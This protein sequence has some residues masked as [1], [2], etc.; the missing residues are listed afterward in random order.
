[1]YAELC[2]VLEEAGIPHN[3]VFRRDHLFNLRNYPAYEVGVPYSL[4]EKAET[5]VKEAFG[6]DD[7][8]DVGA[9]ELQEVMEAGTNRIWKLPETL[10]PVSDEKVPGPPSAGAEAAWF[11][12]DATAKVWE[13][14][15][16]ESSEFLVAALRE[17]GIRCRLDTSRGQAEIYV[18][19]E[20]EHRAREIVREVMEGKPPE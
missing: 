18:L 16:D 14:E 3:T 8:E 20:D 4:Y 12:E 19:P 13:G 10:T 17:N 1:V 6:T 11:E 2:S 9:Q 5:A 7:L 15:S